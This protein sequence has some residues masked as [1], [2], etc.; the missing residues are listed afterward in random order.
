MSILDD[1]AIFIA[2]IQQGGFCHAAKHLG[3]S[4]GLITRRIAQLEKKLGVTLIKRTTRQIQ[5]TPEGTLFWQHAQR[6]Q[7]EMD[8]AVCSIQSY[9][10]KPK[11][12]IRISAAPYFGRHYLTPILTQFLIN[13]TDIK[14]D[15]I[16][17]DQQLDPIKSQLDLIIR[18]AGISTSSQPADSNLQMKILLKDKIYLYASPNYIA[19]HGAPENP[20]ELLSHTTISYSDSKTMSEENQWQYT[21]K[22]NQYI[23]KLKPPF[24]VN[25][26]G[27]ALTAA[28]T[29]FGIGRFNSLVA[30]VALEQNQLVPV[31]K[32][33]DWGTYSLYALYPHQEALPKRTRLLLDY[34]SAHTKNLF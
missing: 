5:L 14:I 16:L 10:Q 17:D 6:I 13:F 21:H 24:N 31:L 15:L 4:N 29:G 7:Q 25:D 27:S 33:Y 11:G 19:K 2:V 34:I 18:S 26:I 30:K 12:R 32:S 8:S 22:D 1:T 20:N 28:A 23:V 9:A 3:F